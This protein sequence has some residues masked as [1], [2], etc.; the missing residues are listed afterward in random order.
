MPTSA[1]RREAEDEAGPRGGRGDHREQFFFF[2]PDLLRSV[3]YCYW[4]P[5]N[6]TLPF[7]IP[8]MIRFAP[9][10]VLMDARTRFMEGIAA[11]LAIILCAIV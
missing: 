11:L 5:R 10:T 8:S 7:A 4:Q 1:G 6:A 9:R 3:T 2:L